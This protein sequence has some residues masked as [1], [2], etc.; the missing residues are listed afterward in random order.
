MAMVQG[1]D[2]LMVGMV[3]WI[4]SGVFYNVHT[5]LEQVYYH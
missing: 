2:V 3:F 4:C 1:N 5:A